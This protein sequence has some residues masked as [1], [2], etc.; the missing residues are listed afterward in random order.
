M[1]K[2]SIKKPLS[3]SCLWLILSLCYTLLFTTIEFHDNPYSSIGGLFNLIIQWGVVATSASGIICILIIN[4]Y[5]FALTFPL[6]I[7]LSTTLSYFHLTMGV[8]LTPMV[9]ELAIINDSNTWATVIS[10][11]LI[12][13]LF[14]ALISSLLCVYYRF[15]YVKTDISWRWLMP[16][17]LLF[18]IL[19]TTIIPR[20]RAAVIS[21]MPYSFYYTLKDY[22]TNRTIIAEQRNTY[23]RIQAI[24]SEQS[25]DVVI[26]IGESLRADHLPQNGYQRNTLP[27]ISLD[28]TIVSLPNMFT[29]EWCTHT[30]VP[31]IM[32]KA[33]SDCPEQAYEE[34]SFITLFKKAGYHTSWI[35]NQDANPTYV[36]FMHEADSLIMSSA[37]KSVY[38]FGKWL[39]SDLLPHIEEVLNLNDLKKLLVIHTIGSH[40]WYRSHYVDSQALFKPEI[41][42]RIL[43]DLSQE[44]II[45][46]YDNSIIATDNFLYDL[47]SKFQDRNAIIIYISDHGEALGENGNYLHADDYPELHNPACLIWYSRKY[48]ELYPKKIE[49]LKKNAK[50]NWSTDDIIHTV[51]DGADIKCEILNHNSSIFNQYIDN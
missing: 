7:L 45:N 48:A 26:V 33:N 9:I 35:S 47:K 32:T 18:I 43:S 22:Y 31:R 20:F 10:Y 16:I 50:R 4:R 3:L 21:R 12:L 36:F 41:D 49:N 34:Q 42:S 6:L 14:F 5:V 23:D 40:W 37:T 44:Q 39:D 17:G 1:T 38:N 27:L 30:S 11:Q 13:L 28:S 2:I 24:C 29:E 46:S 25:P 19:P 8:S 15:F 51:L